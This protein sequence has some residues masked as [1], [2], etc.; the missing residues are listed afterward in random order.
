MVSV[1]VPTYYRDECLCKMIASFNC[2]RYTNFEILVIDQ[3]EKVSDEK[4]TAILNSCS[5]AQYYQ[6][7]ERGRC[8]AK[9]FAIDKAKG[10]ILIFCDDDI[11]VDEHFLDEH[12]RIHTEL[13]G[14]G[15]VSCHL[16]EPHEVP[17]RCDV[18]L[19]ITS[20]GRFI[21]KPN[22][23]F[24][25]FVTSLNGG[26]M[27]FKRAGLEQIGFFDENLK[28]TSMLEEPDMAYRLI[29]KGFRIYFSSRTK[30]QHFPQYNGNINT[31]KGK[32][33]EWLFNYFHNQYFFVLRNRRIIYLPFVVLY[34]T[35]RIA[36]EAITNKIMSLRFLCI[37]FTSL[38]AA[39]KTWEKEK[40][41]YQQ[42]WF[43]KRK[44]TVGVIQY[45]FNEH[46]Q[47]SC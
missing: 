32:R 42:P 21:N 18:P 15:A 47:P 34:L 30:V 10:D 41:N 36:V 43:T 35:Y 19:K 4:V 5:K 9:N 29:Q 25:G 13:P 28:G 26:N 46:V 8:V 33:Q 31:K 2:Q 6:I 38:R 22:A 37:P 11:I 23:L 12:V 7:T 44:K 17:I 1:V 24:E 16:I 20:Y 27:S 39:F 40:Q 3:S 14:V 45:I